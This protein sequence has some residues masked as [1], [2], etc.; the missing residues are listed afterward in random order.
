MRKSPPTACPEFSMAPFC[1]SRRTAATA[2]ATTPSTAATA[3]S[4]PTQSRK[5]KP[6]RIRFASRVEIR[7]HSVI[8]GDHPWCEDGLSL[9][10]GWDYND[11]VVDIARSSKDNKHSRRRNESSNRNSN[12]SPHRR[13]YLERKRVLLEVGGYTERELQLQLEEA[14]NFGTSMSRVGSIKEHLDGSGM[15]Q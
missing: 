5:K 2:T 14:N 1:T 9:D 4:T 11:S 3:F 15:T 10:L 8:L 13:S 12:S 6:Y 7:T